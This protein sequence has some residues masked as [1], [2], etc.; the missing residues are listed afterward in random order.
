MHWKNIVLDTENYFKLLFFPVKMERIDEEIP[1]WI[2]NSKFVIQ[3]NEDFPNQNVVLDA[4]RMFTFP[5]DQSGLTHKNIGKI[6][7]NIIFL[8]IT[9]EQYLKPCFI[10][11]YNS[12]YKDEII[13]DF[14]K[15]TE[16]NKQY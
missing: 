10:F 5:T 7:D 3:F 14:P 16:F 13:R 12:P 4:W 6:L 1:D 11:V 2:E 8:G 9:D 15:V